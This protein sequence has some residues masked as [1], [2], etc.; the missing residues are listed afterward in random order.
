VD[1]IRLSWLHGS[2][3]AGFSVFRGG[4]L[5]SLRVVSKPNHMLKPCEPNPTHTTTF[6]N[7]PKPNQPKTAKSNQTKLQ[8]FPQTRFNPFKNQT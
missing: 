4:G 7:G 3:Q 1:L 6:S 8:S 2:E 5:A